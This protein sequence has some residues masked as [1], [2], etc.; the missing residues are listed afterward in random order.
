[1]PPPSPLTIQTSSITRLVNEHA[2]Y[3]KELK[4]QRTHLAALEK[5]AEKSEKRGEE[6]NGKGDEEAGEDEDED[7][8][9]RF[10]VGQEVGLA[11]FFFLVSVKGGSRVWVGEGRR[12]RREK[13]WEC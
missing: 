3:E 5:S 11:A 1:M 2:S 8:N 4:S 12:Q 6:G 10:R 7:G 13:G 9:L